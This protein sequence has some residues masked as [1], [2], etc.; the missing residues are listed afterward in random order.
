M[1]DRNALGMIGLMLGA[2][3]MFVMMVGAFV[4]GDYLT[5][6]SHLEDRLTEVALPAAE[7]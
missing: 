1:A 7:R 3:T 6:R 4:I 2:A 5:G